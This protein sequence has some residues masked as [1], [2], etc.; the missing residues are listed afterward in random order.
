MLG[1]MAALLLILAPLSYAND[2]HTQT[3]E[4]TWDFIAGGRIELHL[5]CGDLKVS[6][7]DDN[8]ISLRYKMQSEHADFIPRVTT[9]FD[10]TASSALLRV[11][12]PYNGSIDVELKVPARSNI[13][14]RVFAGDIVVGPIEGDKN[15]ETHAGDI[16]INLPEHFDVGAVDAS[17]HAGDVSAPWGKPHGWIGNS[18][19]YAGDGK[20]SIHAHTFAGDIDLK[21]VEGMEAQKCPCD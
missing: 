15:V 17:T 11:S 3:K 7:G 9:K 16:V 1:R 18:L 4:Q 20:Y 10:V 8:H 13:Y 12:G 19:K 14:L 6:P 5:C 21:E 2:H